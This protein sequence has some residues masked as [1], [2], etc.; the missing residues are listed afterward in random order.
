MHLYVSVFTSECYKM[1]IL[2]NTEDSITPPSGTPVWLLLCPQALYNERWYDW[3]GKEREDCRER[4]GRE[5]KKHLS[6]LLFLSFNKISLNDIK[7]LNHVLQ[8]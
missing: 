7:D 1:N 4:G 2:H 3:N 6:S 8:L 5:G